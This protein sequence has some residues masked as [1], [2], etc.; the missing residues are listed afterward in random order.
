MNWSKGVVRPAFLGS[1]WGHFGIRV[2][3]GEY[4]LFEMKTGLFIIGSSSMDKCKAVAAAINHLPWDDV[5]VDPNTAIITGMSEEMRAETKRLAE[6][7][8]FEAINNEKEN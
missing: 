1:I 4:S 3:N 2:R 7:A 6:A 5:K 8:M